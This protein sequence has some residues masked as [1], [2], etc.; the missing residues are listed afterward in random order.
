MLLPFLNN[1]FLL[2]HKGPEW[3]WPTGYYIRARLT[4]A[5]RLIELDKA[6]VHV[7]AKAVR[8]AQEILLRMNNHLRASPW[9]SL[10]ELTQA[11]G[12][13]S[14]DRTRFT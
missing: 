12:E 11:N 10:P 1:T 6:V 8:E 2:P 7:R 14:S 9:R 13:V 5:Q 3:L 4:F